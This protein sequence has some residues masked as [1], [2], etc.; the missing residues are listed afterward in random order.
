MRH[1][2]ATLLGL[3]L[4]LK[5][6]LGAGASANGAPILLPVTNTTALLR[7]QAAL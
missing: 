3:K 6:V 4:A 1:D 2:Q 5:I 7:T